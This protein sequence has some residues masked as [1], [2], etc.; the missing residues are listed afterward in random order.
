M[1]VQIIKEFNELVVAAYL[2]YS[3]EMPCPGDMVTESKFGRIPAIKNCFVDMYVINKVRLYAADVL[4]ALSHDTSL[5]YKRSDLTISVLEQEQ[6]LVHT[7]CVD[8]Y[9]TMNKLCTDGLLTTIIE[10]MTF[11]D[12]VRYTVWAYRCSVARQD[13][14]EYD[15]S[16]G[17]ITF[18]LPDMSVSLQSALKQLGLFSSIV[19]DKVVNEPYEDFVYVPG[20]LDQVEESSDESSGCSCSSDCIEPDTTFTR[21]SI[22]RRIMLQEPATGQIWYKGNF[23]QDTV[24]SESVGDSV[25]DRV[26]YSGKRAKH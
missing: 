6:P 23:Y 18:S 22:K 8:I 1:Q 12:L 24:S 13:D 20:Q 7:L 5:Q 14:K 21:P 3:K 25:C 10:S 2:D 16:F 19:G 9:W 15:S 4:D 11:A 26:V 17:I